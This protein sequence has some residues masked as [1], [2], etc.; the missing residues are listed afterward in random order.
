M[1]QAVQE[2][3]HDLHRDDKTCLRQ[4]AEDPVR[5]DRR[6]TMGMAADRPWTVKEVGRELPRHEDHHKVLVM[7][8]FKMMDTAIVMDHRHGA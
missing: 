2:A 7:V 4:Q 3:A 5:E 1:A 8:V 6:W